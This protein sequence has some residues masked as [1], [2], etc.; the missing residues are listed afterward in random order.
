MPRIYTRDL[1]NGVGINDAN[2]V[3]QP[4]VG[5]RRIVCP[6]FFKWNSMIKRCYDPISLRKHP[7][8]SKCSVDPEWHSF[9][10]F[11]SWMV[12][13]DWE[14]NELDKDLL[15][16]G[17]TYSTSACMFIPEP[18]NRFLKEKCGPTGKCLYGVISKSGRFHSR[19]QIGNRRQFIGSFLTQEEA[20]SAWA[21]VKSEH[22]LKLADEQTDPRIANGLRRYA[23]SIQELAR[24]RL[25]NR[26]PGL[27]SE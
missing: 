12:E 8:Y 5:S 18:I 4:T 6:Y 10:A 22:A 1:V 15:G 3:T 19:I 11:R 13:Q 26:T 27:R 2:Y 9:M 23:T 24:N 20:H 17:K 21:R 14:G 25:E 16:D 7:T